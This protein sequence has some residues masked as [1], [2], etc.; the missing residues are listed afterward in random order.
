MARLKSAMRGAVGGGFRAAEGIDLVVDHGLFLADFLEVL[1]DGGEVLE[2][3]GLG[4]ERDDLGALGEG[5]AQALEGSLDLGPFDEFE[6]VGHAELHAGGDAGE[7]GAVL[8][9]GFEEGV[10]D[11]GVGLI[12]FCLHGGIVQR[13][14]G[15][16]K[17]LVRFF[18]GSVTG[19][20]HWGRCV[21]RFA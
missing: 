4:G 2:C 21:L 11:G 3:G 7:G 16:G 1:T 5:G 8:E 12:G 10:E 19:C 13:V 17:R 6:Q 18:A 15:R 9:E 20:C 14:A